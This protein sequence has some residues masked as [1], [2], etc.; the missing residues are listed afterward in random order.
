[1]LILVTGQLS[2]FAP[3]FQLI[4]NSS[5]DIPDVEP[6]ADVEPVATIV[7]P[8]AIISPGTPFRLEIPSIGVNAK[9][10]QVGLTE[11]NTIDVLN[12]P[13]NVSWFNIGP[14]PGAT[15]SAIIAGHYGRWPDGSPSVFDNLYKIK[16]GDKVYVRDNKGQVFTFTVTQTKIYDA[17]AIVPEI[18]NQTDNAY[19]NIITCNGEW[20]SEDQ[21]YA[22][23]LIVF[24]TADK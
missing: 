1:M 5:S 23:R 14:K 24:T 21:T 8:K 22:K 7:E 3:S 10:E 16:K 6:I 15:G 12:V 19:L 20:L 9:I 18:F 13:D 4:E 2:A 11:D 17:N